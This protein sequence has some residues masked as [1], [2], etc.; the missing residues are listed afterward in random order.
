[1]KRPN[2]ITGLV[3]RVTFHN[4]DNGFCVIKVKVYGKRDLV[5]I[6]GN[7]PT[8]L[9]GEYVECFGDWINDKEHGLQFKTEV[10]KATAPTSLEGI[11]KYLASRLIKGIG[12]VYAKKLVDA[13][14]QQVFSVIEEFPEQ[15]RTVNGLGKS[16]IEVICTSW[17][18][19]KSVR[20]IILFLHGH[21]ISTARATRIYKEYGAEAISIVEANP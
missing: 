14:G 10:L 11:E 4:P 17:Q 15:L 1:M 19:Q 16:R 20:Q 9:A 2:R 18:I 5:T 7:S 6:I 3:E 13:F 8:I 12:P 21:G